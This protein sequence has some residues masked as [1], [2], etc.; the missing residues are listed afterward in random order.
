M[1]LVNCWPLPHWD[2]G[3]KIFV[4]FVHCSSA[5]RTVPGMQEALSVYQK[6]VEWMWGMDPWSAAQS[7]E[8]RK[9]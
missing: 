3:T 2:V 5:P 8:Y 1:I 4:C 7:L 6:E 9:P